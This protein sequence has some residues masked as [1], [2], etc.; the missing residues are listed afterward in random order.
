VRGRAL[1]VALLV[2]EPIGDGKTDIW[3]GC[4]PFMG[5]K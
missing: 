4:L 1:G 2:F 3:N 5:L